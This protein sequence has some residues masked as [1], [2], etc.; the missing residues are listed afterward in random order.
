MSQAGF[1][2]ADGSRVAPGKD[3]RHYYFPAL[4]A[5][6]VYLPILSDTFLFS[7]ACE[8]EMT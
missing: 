3:W 1:L 2:C 8:D 7:R 5:A 6:V 4:S